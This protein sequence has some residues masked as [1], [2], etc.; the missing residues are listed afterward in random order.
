MDVET[1]YVLLDDF[2][3][4]DLST[5]DLTGIDLEGMRWSEHTHTVAG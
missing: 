2:T 5:V 3:Q 4:A 1:L